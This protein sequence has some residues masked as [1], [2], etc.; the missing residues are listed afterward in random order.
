MVQLASS[1]RNVGEPDEAVRL[2][3]ALVEERPD[4]VGIAAFRALALHSAGRSDEALGSL[5]AAVA[6][7]STDEDVTRYRRSLTAYADELARPGG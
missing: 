6:H 1:L 5:L 2:L 3:D 7:S 4:S